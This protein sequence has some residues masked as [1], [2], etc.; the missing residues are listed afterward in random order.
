MNM[1]YVE[2]CCKILDSKR[3]SI[4]ASERKKFSVA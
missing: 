3:D 4:T 2:D 1:I